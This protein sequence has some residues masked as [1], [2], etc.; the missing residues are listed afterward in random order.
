[1]DLVKPLSLV[2]FLLMDDDDPSTF[3]IVFLC[4]L[5]ETKLFG[6]S[7]MAADVI[8]SIRIAWDVLNRW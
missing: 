8:I 5:L 1:M 6:I 4:T 3:L 7:D 2:A